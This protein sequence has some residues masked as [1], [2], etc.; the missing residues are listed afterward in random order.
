MSDAQRIRT[1]KEVL[2]AVINELNLDV[3]D[4]FTRILAAAFT[5]QDMLDETKAELA[6]AQAQL[7]L[8]R[9]SRSFGDRGG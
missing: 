1:K 9:E 2:K 5:L 6:R 8:M 7:Y 3:T 4:P